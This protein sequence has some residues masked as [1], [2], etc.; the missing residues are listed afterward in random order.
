M[1]KYMQFAEKGS[2]EI[3]PGDGTVTGRFYCIKAA[4]RAEA[5]ATIIFNTDAV[6][7]D[8]TRTLE[9]G[10]GEYEFGPIASITVTAGTIR[11]YINTNPPL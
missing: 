11:A 3:V 9:L 7:T 1:N 2:I 5:D 4:Q 8:G 6:P 10:A